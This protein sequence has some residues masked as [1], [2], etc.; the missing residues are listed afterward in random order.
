M[1]YQYNPLLEFLGHLAIAD[2][3]NTSK[4]IRKYADSQYG[5][6]KWSTPLKNRENFKKAA[7]ELRS[8]G[9]LSGINLKS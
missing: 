7:K 3:I 9:E 2:T 1:K 8:K 6:A 4:K 5:K